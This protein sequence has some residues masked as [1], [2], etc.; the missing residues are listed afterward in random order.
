MIATKIRKA[1][2]KHVES[3]LY[4]FK[5]TKKEIQKLRQEIVYGS[6][7]NDENVGAGKN[8]YRSPGRPTEMIATRLVTDKRL[9]NLEE[10]VEAIESVYENLSDEQRDLINLRYWN[11]KHSWEHIAE[12]CNMSERTVYR[13][14]KAIICTIAEKVGWR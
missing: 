10:I 3:E 7:S 9:R 1:T 5:D 2:F 13:H 6:T 8:S 14:R 4:S 12:K 11:G